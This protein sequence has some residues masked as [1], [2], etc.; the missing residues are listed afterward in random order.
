MYSKKTFQPTELQTRQIQELLKSPSW[1]ALQEW[2]DFEYIEWCK[3]TA[4]LIPKLD[5]MNDD[6]K[7]TLERE[8]E[9]I[10]AVNEWK[11]RVKRLG[12]EYIGESITSE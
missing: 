9:A 8:Y 2:I 7:R 1:V 6:D 10:N 4:S 5:L 3:Y 12:N 11:E